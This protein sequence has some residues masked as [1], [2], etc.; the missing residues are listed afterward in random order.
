MKTPREILLA[1]HK[2]AEAKLDGIRHDAVRVA[3]DVNRRSPPVRE[4]TFAATLQLRL[5]EGLWPCPQAWAGVAT[6]W[7]VILAVNFATRE[8][9]PRNFARQVAPPSPEMLM[10]LRQ[11]QLLLAELVERPEPRAADRPKAVPP[12]PRSDCY[13]QSAAV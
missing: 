10:V 5:R 4:L 12:R 1:R 8:T 2:P 3:A 13:R 6:V 7:L 9:T 11:Q